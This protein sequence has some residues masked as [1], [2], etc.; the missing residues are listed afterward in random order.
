VEQMRS[1]FEKRRN[2][3]VEFIRSMP[4]LDCNMPEGA[5]YVFVD[6][7]RTGMNGEEFVNFMI[8]NGVGMV[9]GTAFGKSAEN[10][11]RLSYAASMEEIEECMRRLRAALDTLGK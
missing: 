1:E 6:V 10:F 9:P 11:V 7:S 4:L 2:Y 8:H 3:V 5:F